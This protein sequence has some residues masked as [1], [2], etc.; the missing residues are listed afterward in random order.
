MGGKPTMIDWDLI[1]QTGL[2]K[3][4]KYYN[5]VA[6]KNDGTCDLKDQ[7][8]A[9][10]R[11][12]DEQDAIGRYKWTLPKEKI[13][14]V[15]DEVERLVYYKGQIVLFKYKATDEYMMM[16]YTGTRID[17]NGRFSRCTPVPIS[18]ESENS[19][20]QKLR[21]ELS[22]L[23]LR[24][25][26]TVPTDEEIEKAGGPYNCAV[27]IRDYPNQNNN[28]QIIPRWAL[29]DPM[30]D[31]EAEIF[32]M[33]RTA[34]KN[35][36]GVKGMEVN[37]EDEA[38]QVEDANEKLFEASLKGDTYIPILKKPSTHD[39][40][41]GNVAKSE[42]WMLALQSMEN[43]RLG[44]YGIQNNGLFEKK[45]HVLEGEQDVNAG[46]TNSRM[47]R[48]LNIRKNSCEIA[49]KIWGDK[50][51]CEIEQNQ[52]GEFFSTD[53]RKESQNGNNRKSEDAS[54]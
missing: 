50:F 30:L 29:N 33:A 3:L 4:I 41:D 9:I 19:L 13:R 40:Q 20:G 34:R 6:G 43:F 11:I 24:I 21:D 31:M 42:E 26:Y 36:T 52:Q 46:P 10:M 22:N 2:L 45:A 27:I 17:F 5:K 49:T 18:N 37:D 39:L 53:N 38:Q 32:P 54:N 14:M 1:Q 48:G 44:T 51:D 12:M 23:S 15:S 16:P 8:R 25:F 7:M 47:Q 35:S 28:Q